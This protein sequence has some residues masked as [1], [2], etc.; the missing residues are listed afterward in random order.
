MNGKRIDL[1][2]YAAQMILKS[3][4]VIAFT[5]AGVSAESGIPTFRDKGGLWERFPVEIFGTP[6]GLISVLFSDPERF[7]EFV[8]STVDV[9]GEAKPNL[10]HIALAELEN[11]QILKA[12]ITQ[13]IDNLHQEAGNKNVI[14]VHGSVTRLRCIVCGEKK[15]IDKKS[16]VEK[17]V[18]FAE[19]IRGLDF[20]RFISE[21]KISLQEIIQIFGDAIPLCE[22]GGIMRPDVVFFT[23]PVQDMDIAFDYARRADCCIIAGTSGVV[24]PAA[25]IPQIVKNNG[26]FLIEI[27]PTDQ[28]FDSDVYIKSSFASSMSE[29]LYKVRN[30]LS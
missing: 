16:F 24:Y 27:N 21:S 25:Y 22:C 17:A 20:S 23:E 26:G 15:R 2:E 1:V 29:I 28:Y 10:G 9:L 30:L 6:R 14:E 5:G 18:K 19:K 11:M 12:V 7:S 3:E 8:I 13:N 4:F